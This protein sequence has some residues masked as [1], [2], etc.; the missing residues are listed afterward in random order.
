MKTLLTSALALSLVVCGAASA[1]T[2][3]GNSADHRA[4]QGA[5]GQDAQRP[6]A[7]RQDGYH[8]DG[9][10]Q[11]GYGQG[12]DRQD[13]NRSADGRGQGYASSDGQHHWA[14]GQRLPASY[15]QDGGRYV[16]Y[17]A[18]HLRRPPH[19]YRWVRTDDNRYA[20]VAITTGVIATLIAASR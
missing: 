1:Q 6:D 20:M 15:Y 19:G 7:V 13:G 8:Q 12:G 4:D 2:Y 3:G 14:R 5:Y 17:R 11:D 10:R 16:D 18:Y 9:M